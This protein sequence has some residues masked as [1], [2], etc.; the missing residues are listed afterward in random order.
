TVGGTRADHCHF[1]YAVLDNHIHMVLMLKVSSQPVGSPKRLLRY[2]GRLF[3]PQAR[4]ASRWKPQTPWR[5]LS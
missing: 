2:L 3:P 4:I 1:G 5:K